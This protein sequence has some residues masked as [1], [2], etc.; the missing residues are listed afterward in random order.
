[1]ETPLT[2][3]AQRLNRFPASPLCSITWFMQGET[4]IVDPPPRESLAFIPAIF[5][6]PQSR[7]IV[8]HNPGPVEMFA[9]MFFPDAL[10]RLAG[11]DMAGYVDRFCPLHEVLGPKWVAMADAVLHAPDDGARV[12]LIERFLDPLWRVARSDEQCGGRT[13]DWVRHLATQAAASAH[14]N[15]VRTVERRIKTWAGQ[16]MRTLR[17]MSRAEQAFLEVRAQISMGKVSWADVA[18]HSGYSDQAHLAREAR[19]I[20]GLS[21]T[22]LARVVTEDESCWVYRIWS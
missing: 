15:G 20:T 1:M 4:E 12:A 17:R 5:G 13:G 3:P 10:H 2:A 8:S 9:V 14:G 19:K 11:L 16:S 22:E 7:P 18:A 21:P 6:G